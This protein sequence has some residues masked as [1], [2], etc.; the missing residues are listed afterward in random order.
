MIVPSCSSD[1]GFWQYKSAN[2]NLDAQIMAIF[3][4]TCLASTLLGTCSASQTPLTT[5]SAPW[6]V[7]NDTVSGRLFKGTPLG[8]PCMVDSS[9]FDC[10]TLQKNYTDEVFRAS[11]PGGFI[12]TQWE[13]CQA[14]G[15]QC[16]LDERDP[17]DLSPIKP[18]RSCSLGSVSP[19]FIDVRSPAD[20][21]AS[22]D[23]S[24]KYNI[25]LVIKNTGHDYK[26]RSSAPN[27]LALWTHNLK[28]ISYDANFIPNMC[29]GDGQTVV[30]VGA[31]IQWHELYNFANERNL[32][33]VGGTDRSVGASGGWV[34]GGGH[35]LL[36]NTMGLGVDRVL[37]FR[38]VTPDGILRI[39]NRCQNPDLFFALRGG[40]G[41]TFGVVLES[42]HLVSPNSPV[43]AVIVAWKDPDEG[44]TKEM[45]S[46]MADNA[47]AWAKDGW[48]AISRSEV[49]VY[50]TPK[51][52][53]A[54]AAKS[55]AP[56]IQFGQRLKKDGVTGATLLVAEFPSYGTF[57]HVFSTQYVASVGASLALTSRLVSKDNF[58]TPE[59]REELVSA[60]ITTNSI[61][62]GL[63]LMMSTPASF[64]GD[65]MTSVTEAWRSSIYHV[66]AISTWNWNA[67]VDEKRAHYNT[68]SNAIN[69]LR[70]ITPD[71][72][73]LNEADVYEPNH[74]VSFWGSNYA[75]LLE[76]KNKYD[77][78]RLLDCWQCVGWNP[79]AARF[80]CYL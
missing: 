66:T 59:K 1:G 55:L 13:T 50:V 3:P 23:F 57:F 15:E 35:S 40:G 37:Q 34:Q 45:W 41:G 62:P 18:P 60:L 56:L 26:G 67:T 44:L 9:S 71:A 32:T 12:N 20:V 5:L 7:L 46:I 74:E 76:I 48:G 43:Q 38:V 80:S 28:D 69:H 17:T 27:S 22:L 65:G 54:E 10:Q 53:K 33:I 11:I 61:T 29:E 4:L 70:A 19:Y 31:G 21:T 51:L 64:P 49:A 39:A 63:I 6:H 2:A 36:S 75:R 68:A 52:D 73:Y 42:T 8:H 30:T 47:L 72:A 78:D 14:T 24:R 79:K 25:P 77:P 58:S 16:L